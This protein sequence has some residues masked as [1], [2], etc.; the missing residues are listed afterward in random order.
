MPKDSS[1]CPYAIVPQSI[2]GSSA[3]VP[4]IDE[5][6]SI[7][8]DHFFFDASNPFRP[9]ELLLNSLA[10]SA[11]LKLGQSRVAHWRVRLFDHG[12]QVFLPANRQNLLPRFSNRVRETLV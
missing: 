4:A 9:S 12:A 11:Q 3:S 5:P 2:D 10:P 6:W 1:G 8:A 7:S